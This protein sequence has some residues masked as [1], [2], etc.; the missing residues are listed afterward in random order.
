MRYEELP[1]EI[2]VTLHL[3]TSFAHSLHN[4]AHAAHT[5]LAPGCLSPVSRLKAIFELYNSTFATYISSPN[6]LSHLR[7]ISFPVPMRPWT[8]GTGDRE[9]WKVGRECEKVQTR[10]AAPSGQDP[11]DLITPIGLTLWWP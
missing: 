11:Q 6:T 1:G 9:C 5:R 10:D 3:Q 4:N 2:E 7:E 8:T